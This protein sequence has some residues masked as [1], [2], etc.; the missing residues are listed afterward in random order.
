MLKLDMSYPT[1]RVLT[2]ARFYNLFSDIELSSVNGTRLEQVWFAF[3]SEIMEKIRQGNV[4]DFLRIDDDLETSFATDS[5]SNLY[6]KKRFIEF[7]SKVDSDVGRVLIIPLNSNRNA[8]FYFEAPTSV[9]WSLISPKGEVLLEG[10]TSESWS[11]RLTEEGYYGLVVASSS[12][13]AED[14]ALTVDLSLV[15]PTSTP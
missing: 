1:L 8:D 12:N 10:S 15:S 14:F 3:A 6:D 7:Q 13:G 5:R 11:G 2:D 4:H 9:Q